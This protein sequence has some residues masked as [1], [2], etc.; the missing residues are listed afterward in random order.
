M[1]GISRCVIGCPDPVPEFS[2]E[3][4]SALHSA[5]LIVQMGVA[6]EECEKLIEGYTKLATTKLQKM[7]R[8]HYQFFGRPLGF[9]HCSVVDSD[10]V[11]AFANNGNA[12]A[13]NFGGQSLSFR[14]VSNGENNPFL[15]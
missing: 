7:A 5:G 8:K 9:L 10:D 1:A 13:R 12:F 14:D 3:G 15:C 4:A 6:G 2:S 11:Q